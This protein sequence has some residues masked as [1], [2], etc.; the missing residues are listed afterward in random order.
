MEIKLEKERTFEEIKLEKEGK[1]G[2]AFFFL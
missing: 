1:N 2:K